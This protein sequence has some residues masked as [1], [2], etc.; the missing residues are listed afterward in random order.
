MHPPTERRRAF[1]LRIAL[2]AGC[3]V[4]VD[5]V[6]KSLVRANYP[7]CP[8]PPCEG[9]DLGVVRFVNARNAGSALGHAPGLWLWL[10]LA[11]ASVVMIFAFARRMGGG[12]LAVAGLALL[13]G[14]AVS[15]L[16]DRVLFG[17]ATDYVQLAFGP[18]WNLADVALLCG[19]LVSTALLAIRPDARSDMA[20]AV[21][22]E[23]GV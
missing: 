7:A 5:Q 23:A 20:D 16:A 12:P 14:G 11:I 8:N 2:V 1:V 4:L 3:V 6:C 10:V 15:N 9:L 22:H 19:A 21:E 17:G 13:L 18:V